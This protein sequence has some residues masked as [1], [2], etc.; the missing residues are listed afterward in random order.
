MDE[1]ISEQKFKIGSLARTVRRIPILIFILDEMSLRRV[2]RGSR[3][4][5]ALY[6]TA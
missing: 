4:D 5:L 1:F 6:I 3:V 2:M